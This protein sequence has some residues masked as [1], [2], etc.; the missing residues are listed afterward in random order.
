MALIEILNQKT[1]YICV[2][3]SGGVIDGFFTGPA[4][5]IAV[6]QLIDEGLVRDPFND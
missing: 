5:C 6:Q 2:D 1:G 4:L 3:G